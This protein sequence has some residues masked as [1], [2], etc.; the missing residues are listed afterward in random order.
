MNGTK[1]LK[2]LA[3]VVVVLSIVQMA[4]MLA[5]F[6]GCLPTD[7]SYIILQYARQITQGNWF[8]YNDGQMS[9]GITCPL[10][11]MAIAGA[12]LIFN[13]WHFSLLALG[14]ACWFVSLLIGARLAWKMAGWQAVTAWCV[15]FGLCGRIE[16]FMLIGMETALAIPLALAAVWAWLE[17][18][19]WLT[20]LLVAL[21]TL[22][23]PEAFLFILVFAIT[24]LLYRNRARLMENAWIWL[25]FGIVL[26]PWLIYCWCVSHTIGPS[27][28]SLKEGAPALHDSLRFTWQALFLH[29]PD[30]FDSKLVSGCGVQSSAW[31]AV[32]S[33][34]PLGLLAAG[35]WLA[36]RG[37]RIL[38]LPLLFVPAHIVLAAMKHPDP[39]GAF[40]RYMPIDYTLVYLYA[41]V[42]FGWLLTIKWAKGAAGVVLLAT[43]ILLVMDSSY[44]RK[45]YQIQA[46][47]FAQLDY[48]IGAWLKN[49]TPANTV[50]AVYQAGGIRWF[51]ERQIIDLGAVTDYSTHGIVDTPQGRVQL[52]RERNADYVASFGDEWLDGSACSLK[53]HKYF[54]R[55]PLQCRGLWKI[56]KDALKSVEP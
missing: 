34:V 23:R 15:F 4:R 35:A 46:S 51:G 55:V 11:A 45:S 20:G 33:V 1:F 48:S 39:G 49:N 42:F 47:Y 29:W 44:C 25:W 8:C 22:C 14:V 18:R 53:D 3:G 52:I 24:I 5:A 54:E 27:T 10:Y 13:N 38:L 56:N 17:S 16:C 32:K 2:W 28:I 19:Y 9:S 41:A 31:M 37:K 6:P 12:N 50:V 43:A 21:V 40:D 30:T 7:D 26:V 36:L